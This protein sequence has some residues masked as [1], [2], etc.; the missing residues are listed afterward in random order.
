MRRQQRIVIVGAGIVGLSTAY[1]LLTQGMRHV[2]VLEQ[3]AIDHSRCSSHGFSRLLRFEYGSD[4]FY[5]N[6]VRLS[7]KRWRSL[8]RVSRRTLYTPSGVLVLG[9]EDDNFTLPSYHVA[10]GLGLPVEHLSR[11]QCRQ[12]FPQFDTQPYGMLTYNREAGILYASACLRTLRDLIL[13]LGGEVYESCRVAKLTNDNQ[14]SPVRLHVSGGTEISAERVVLTTGSWV[15]RLLAGLRLPV[16]ITRQYLLYFAGL[17]RSLFGAGTFPAFMS[18]D[19]YG[20]PIHKGCN[21]WVKATS[22]RFGAPVDPDEV[23]PPDA[24]V[25]AQITRQLREL[26]PGL[27]R[28]ELVRVDSCMY[29]VTPDENFI[30]DHL[31]YDPRV[32]FATG[33]TGHGFKFGPLLGELLSSMVRGT[34]PPVPLD[35]FRLSRFAHQ[36]T[37]QSIS[38]A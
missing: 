11:D 25:I 9:N 8:E 23:T 33:F 37:Y 4:S 2:I 6:M 19:L 14:Q 12:R 10:R 36:K 13:E 32:I 18:Q 26:L 3:E 35:R 15:H 16:Q 34:Q 27:D 21:G 17:P 22:H 29:D 28:A 1:T 5:S 31:P 20:F 38:I 30:L 24:R 7:L